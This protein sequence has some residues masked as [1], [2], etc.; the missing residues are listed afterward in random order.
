M[1]VDL[2]GDGVGNN[3][4][5]SLSAWIVGL[6]FSFRVINILVCV[7]FFQLEPYTGAAIGLALN[8][9][10]FC[11]V[12]MDRIGRPALP[13]ETI[14][15]APERRWVLCF[16]AMS[17]L[18]LIWTATASTPAA[19]AF[20]FAMAA[21]TGMVY[22]LVCIY[23]VEDVAMEL[24]KGFVA[25]A[26]AVAAVAWI[27][28]AQ[29]DLRLGDEQLLG[30]N[31]IGYVCAFAFF[32]SQYLTRIYGNAW[33]WTTALLGLT[34]V[35]SLSKTTIGALLAAQVFLLLRDRHFTR[36][37][38]VLM[39]SAS[40]AIIAVFWNLFFSYADIYANAGNQA[41]TLTGRLGL[42]AIFLDESLQRPWIGHGFHSVWKVILPFG[43]D[44]FEARHAHNELLQQF[45]AYGLMGVIVVAGLYRS[46][47]RRVRTL[48]IGH[49][50]SLMLSLFVFIL[51]R[52][53]ADTEPFD[54]SLP[55]WA[56]TLFSYWVQEEKG[57]RPAPAAL[58]SP[59]RPI[60]EPLSQI[61]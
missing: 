36:K 56:I 54:L 1:P 30:P 11:L 52:G 3:A 19:I 39:I 58:N 42:W 51:V 34:V 12:V 8:F 2:Q 45:Y 35:R 18:S 25:G 31:Q 61:T 7:R 22:V 9:F 38:R 33:A 60:G 6:F 55:L 44:Q 24:M 47:W 21:D 53:L 37:T 17:A 10:L 59:L 5:A 41:E 14:F 26:C 50:R 23:P 40:L 27:L 13:R 32:F 20:W 16:F 28:P 48:P 49:L 46:F 29:S 15:A 57:R 4:G 43:P